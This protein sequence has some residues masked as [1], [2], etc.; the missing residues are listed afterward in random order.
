MLFFALNKTWVKFCKYRENSKTLAHPRDKNN[1]VHW[2]L[3]YPHVSVNNCIQILLRFRVRIVVCSWRLFYCSVV[4]NKHIQITNVTA[5][6]ICLFLQ[7]W[8][9]V[10]WVIITWKTFFTILNKLSEVKKNI[11]GP[12]IQRKQP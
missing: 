3:S 4:W 8:I 9:A 12:E 5:R 1:K 11:S 6:A 7:V 2:K 10:R